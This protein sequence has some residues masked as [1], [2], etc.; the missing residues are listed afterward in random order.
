MLTGLLA[1][2]LF[3]F[4]TVILDI[5][6]D[7]PI[8]SSSLRAVF[9]APYISNFLQF[10]FSA[11]W[12][13]VCLGGKRQFVQT[14][15][16]IK[17]KGGRMVLLASLLGGPVGMSAYVAA[18]HYSGPAFTAAVS[19]LFPAVGALLAWLFLKERLRKFQLLGLAVSVA[20]VTVLG[21]EPGTEN[22]VKNGPLGFFFAMLCCLSWAL[23]TVL[24]SWGF[25]QTELTMNQA[26]LL[27][28]TASAI[29]CGCII[30]PL[31]QGWNETIQVLPD[32]A[33]VYIFIGALSFTASY[34]FYYRAI[35]SLGAAKA[36][37]LNI[38]YTAWSIIFSLL[39]LRIVPS[40]KSVIC[41]TLIVGG[42][43]SASIDLN[44]RE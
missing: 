22:I 38:T 9:L 27:R 23:E 25:R 31:L 17:N 29:V 34:L 4:G 44:K 35:V 32:K 39:L 42:S 12:L 15:H 26:L 7:L 13:A 11:A 14:F 5:A 37:A 21:F 43:L 3:A 18:V 36:M 24:F 41:S 30:L 8:Y 10:A 28:Q 2:V 40:M 20:G 1:G 19:A 6:M 16:C 33:T